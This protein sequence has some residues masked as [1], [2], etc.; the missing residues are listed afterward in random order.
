MPRKL[1]PLTLADFQ[2]LPAGCSSCVFWETEGLRERR[3]GSVCDSEKQAEWYHDVVQTWGDCGRIAIE[4]DEILGFIK[5]A[6]SGYFPQSRSFA[7]A[8]SDLNVPLIACM[9]VESHARHHGLGTVMLRA[10]LRDLVSRG[11]RKV[12]CFAMAHKPASLD[13]APMPSIDFLLRNGFK[14]AHPDPVYPLLQL[15]LRSLA[16]WTENLEA[17]LESLKLPLSIPKRAPA[18]W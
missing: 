9:H 5:Y 14:V 16:V 6:P 8:P 2:R 12:E 15:E 7:S 13:E 18:P 4:D 1:R 3:C 11:E 10:A 17:A